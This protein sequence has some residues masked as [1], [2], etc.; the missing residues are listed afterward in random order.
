MCDEIDP[1]LDKN[2]KGDEELENIYVT[3]LTM[4][5]LKNTIIASGDDGFVSINKDNRI[6]VISLGKRE[7]H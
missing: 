7:N 3:F 4:G 6:I 2:V 5:F 1:T